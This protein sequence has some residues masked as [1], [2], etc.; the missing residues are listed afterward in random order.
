M[1]IISGTARG[2]HLL[3]P[4]WTNTRPMMD[5]VK[6]SL[7][8]TIQSWIPDA[9]VLD[10][11]AGSGALGIEALSRGAQSVDFVDISRR[12]CDLIKKNLQKSKLEEKATLYCLRDKKFL[13]TRA[14]SYQ[15]L[16]PKKHFYDVIFFCPPY[17]FFSLSMLE[18]VVTLLGNDSLLIAEHPQKLELPPQFDTTSLWKQKNFGQ[19]TL[20]Y[21]LAP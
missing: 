19:T 10:L 3:H 7:F 17:D 1:R 12:C 4:T 6:E 15:Q 5:K 13:R 2:I 9:I 16:T 14:P 18:Q 20:S 11:Y 8:S 21:Y